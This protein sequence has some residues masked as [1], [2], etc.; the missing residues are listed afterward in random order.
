MKII[1]TNK[2]AYFDYEVLEELVAGMVLSGP[3]IKS[4]RAGHVNLKGAY[5]SIHGGEA[6]LKNANI[7]RYPYDTS[8]TYDPFRDRKL[9][10]SKKEIERLAGKLNAQGTTL[11]ALAIGLKGP[12]AKLVVG[13]VRGKKKHDKRQV[14]K[15]RAAA[16]EAGRAMKGFNR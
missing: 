5:V 12:Y 13:L 1:H 15:D 9:L 8:G 3:E 10:L 6:F 16:R 14:I 4:V 2:K 7:A 11:A